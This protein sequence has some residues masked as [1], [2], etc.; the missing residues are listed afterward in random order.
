MVITNNKP[1]ENGVNNLA[2][3]A[4]NEQGNIVDKY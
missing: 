2:L 4:N 1:N 3:I